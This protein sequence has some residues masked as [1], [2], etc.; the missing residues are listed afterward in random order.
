MNIKK[1]RK[2]VEHEYTYIYIDEMNLS[3]ASLTWKKDELKA[4]GS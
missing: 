2:I 3:T 4:K 1:I